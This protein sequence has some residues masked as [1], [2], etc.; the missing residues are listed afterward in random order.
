MDE[1]MNGSWDNRRKKVFS[2]VLFGLFV[3]YFCTHVLAASKRRMGETNT[4]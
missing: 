3:A 2:D 4:C 1:W